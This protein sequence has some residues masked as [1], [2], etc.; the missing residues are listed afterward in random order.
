LH[1]EQSLAEHKLTQQGIEQ[2]AKLQVS[3]EG[4]AGTLKIGALPKKASEELQAAHAEASREMA[5]ALALK[6]AFVVLKQAEQDKA[7]GRSSAPAAKRLKRGDEVSGPR[8]EA[9][10]DPEAS[11]S[12][13][14]PVARCTAAPKAA[15]TAAPKAAP[16]A[17]PK[18]C[19]AKTSRGVPCK[20]K[21]ADGDYC[22][23]HSG[24][25][26]APGP[27]QQFLCAYAGRCTA[28]VPVH[29]EHCAACK[30]LAE[31][32]AQER[33]QLMLAASPAPPAVLAAHA[34]IVGDAAAA[35][36][37]PE[38]AAAD[39]IEHEVV[40]LFDHEILAEAAE[41]QAVE[42]F[43]LPDWTC[44]VDGCRRPKPCHVHIGGPN[45][46]EV[47]KVPL[48]AMANGEALDAEDVG[49]GGFGNRQRAPPHTPC[50]AHDHDLGGTESRSV[51]G[52]SLLP[53]AARFWC[54][55]SYGRELHT[56]CAAG[57]VADY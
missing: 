3:I 15:P 9:D 20:R 8:A 19:Q 54:P 18:T 2:V 38:D 39:A 1:H 5:K 53:C 46:V 43:P 51:R 7:K 49:H 35:A 32:L 10:H 34:A 30:V 29:G 36:A 33:V 28:V 13:A 27:G 24:R 23:K 22:C 40:A 57:H 42:A 45:L 50:E 26:P 12:A 6:Q 17:V 31:T 44:G 37:E 41:P 56:G 4:V 48:P 11:S 21:V 55:P 52:T 14:P 25:L 16:K 47:G